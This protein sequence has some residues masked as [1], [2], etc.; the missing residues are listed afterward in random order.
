MYQMPNKNNNKGRAVKVT[1]RKIRYLWN[2]RKTF[3]QV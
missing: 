2:C 3:R 1:H